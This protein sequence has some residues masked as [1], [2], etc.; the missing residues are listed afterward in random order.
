[1]VHCHNGVAIVA[2]SVGDLKAIGEVEDVGA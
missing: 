2:R 1:M